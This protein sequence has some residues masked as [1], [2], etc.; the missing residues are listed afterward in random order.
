[1]VK[2]PVDFAWILSEHLK[3]EAE[4]LLTLTDIKH[5][6][7]T[8][9]KKVPLKNVYID[10]KSKKIDQ[11]VCQVGSLFSRRNILVAPVLVDYRFD[12]KFG[13]HF[14]LAVSKDKLQ[15][16]RDQS[17]IPTYSEAKFQEKIAGSRSVDP[18]DNYD[19][20]DEANHIYSLL[21][22]LTYE[23]QSPENNYGR[24]T[25]FIVD[26]DSLELKFLVID[27]GINFHP[28]LKIIPIDKMMYVDWFTNSIMVNLRGVLGRDLAPLSTQS[29][30]RYH[31]HEVPPMV[32]N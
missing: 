20:V 4:L 26:V 6:I 16:F 13:Y 31:D 3:L 9:D 23:V 24:F 1:M 29:L 15:S 10:M 5:F 30:Y 7:S 21:E 28:Q 19:P 2:A 27:V 8:D 17:A 18:E 12:P 32:L 25:D 14:E 11:L 22:L